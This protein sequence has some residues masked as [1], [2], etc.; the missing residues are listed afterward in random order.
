LSKLMGKRTSLRGPIFIAHQSI[1]LKENVRINSYIVTDV[2]IYYRSD[3][4]CE[5]H[6]VGASQAGAYSVIGVFLEVSNVTQSFIGQFSNS[7]PKTSNVTSVI[8]SLNF[9][10][11]SALLNKSSIYF[12]H[13]GL[14]TPPCTEGVKFS[15]IQEP[16]RI[17]IQEYLAIKTPYNARPVQLNNYKPGSE[18]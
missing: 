13:G 9:E 6:F 2:L 18:I 4:E 8:P 1:S 12:Y 7:I 16:M 11:L 15:I 17:S 5:M 10:P 3:Y 14:T